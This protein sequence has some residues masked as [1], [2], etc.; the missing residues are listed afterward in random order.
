MSADIK[1]LQK[2]SARIRFQAEINFSQG[3]IIYVKGEPDD[4]GFYLGEVDGVQGLVPSNYLQEIEEFADEAGPSQPGPPS[5][6]G[7]V[8]PMAR[9]D[10]NRGHGPGA[11]GPPPPPRDGMPP[12]SDLR[13]RRKGTH[14]F[15]EL[16]K[17][18][19]SLSPRIFFCLSSINF[20]FLYRINHIFMFVTK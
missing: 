11:R 20:F 7:P 18:C 1:K 6:G 16:Y 19:F 4:D 13:D 15:V 17:F 10:R 12:R 5:R 3:Q 9:G 2:P 14:S 8:R